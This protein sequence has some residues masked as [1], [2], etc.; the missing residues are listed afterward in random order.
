MKCTKCG[1]KD[2]DNSKFC[3]NCGTKLGSTKVGGIHFATGSNISV[4]GDF[5]GGDKI[6]GD[7]IV[8]QKKTSP[9]TEHL[10]RIIREQF[11]A[12]WMDDPDVTF[13]D[14]NV[15]VKGDQVGGDKFIGNKYVP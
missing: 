3:G 10:G 14:G 6:V 15:I 11:G 4:S 8:G 5:V 13:E 9:D 12:D 1:Q 7:K 2:Q